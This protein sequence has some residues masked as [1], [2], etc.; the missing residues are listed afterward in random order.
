MSMQAKV[1]I[2]FLMVGCDIKTKNAKAATG[3]VLVL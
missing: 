3:G 1:P 2:F